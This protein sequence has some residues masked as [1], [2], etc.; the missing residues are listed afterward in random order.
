ME[1][2]ADAIE[3]ILAHWPVARLAMVGEGGRPALVPVVFARA[4]GSLWS[5]VDG[6]PKRSAQLAR[7]RHVARNPRVALLLDHYDADWTRL[8]WLRVD[9]T[10]RVR[11]AP[12]PDADP[13]LAEA[14]LALREK[15]PQYASV[16]L[17][18]GEPT[19]LALTPERTS[20]WCASPASLGALAE[21]G[22]R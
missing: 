13:E 14:A 19:L 16:A 8:W 17:F 21:E 6:K 1:I 12:D 10:A 18:R 11:S 22:I 3:A 2:P 9:A 4:A 7:L 15:Y 5:P 20:S